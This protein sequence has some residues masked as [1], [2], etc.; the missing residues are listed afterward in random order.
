M[1]MRPSMPWQEKN[2]QMF[3]MTSGFEYTVEMPMLRS[4]PNA[5]IRKFRLVVEVRMLTSRI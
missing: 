5:H 3:L 1:L 2:L 4:S